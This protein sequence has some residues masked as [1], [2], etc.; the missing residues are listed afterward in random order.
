MEKRTKP[1]PQHLSKEGKTFWNRIL[2]RYD[3]EEHELRVLQA[4]IES[5]ER[6]QAAREQLGREGLTIAG[7]EGGMR[8]HPCIGIERDAK[9]SF[10]QLIK[11]LKLNED[12]A[13]KQMGRPTESQSKYNKRLWDVDDG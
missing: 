10:A 1:A 3:M 6:M 5:W 7:R 8:A 9:A 11:Q 12:D 4:A 2:R 13:P